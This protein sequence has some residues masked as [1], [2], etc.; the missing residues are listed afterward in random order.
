MT[1]TAILNSTM[2]PAL[3]LL[4]AVF[5]GHAEQLGRGWWH[6]RYVTYKVRN[7][8]A[9]YQGDI[10]L[11]N[12]ADIPTTPPDQA[13]Q[14][15]A[16]RPDGAFLTGIGN[17]NL[18]PGGIV[19]Y[20]IA[21]GIKGEQLA[22]V[23][24]AMQTYNNNTPVKWTPRTNQADYV[25]IVSEPADSGDCGS[26]YVGVNGGAQQLILN[27]AASCGYL[28]SATHE[29]GHALGF[30]HEQT[31]FDRDYY[32]KVHFENMDKNQV[33]QYARDLGQIDILPYN[34][35][36]IMHYGPEDDQRN[37]LLTMETIPPGIPIAHRSSL[38]AGD[39]E[40][41]RTVYGSPSS[42]VTVYTD[43]PG[44][45]VIVDGQSVTTPMVF[46]WTQGSS[47]TLAVA[48]G[49]QK[50]VNGTRYTFARWSNDGPKVQTITASPDTR[51]VG[52]NFSAQF[53][54]T[55]KVGQAG[56]GS[57]TVDP[58]SPDGYYT[59][60][61]LLT[62]TASP[63]AGNA[64]LQWD[65]PG[66]VSL[67][68]GD[69]SNP[70][71]L[72]VDAA[73]YSYVADFTKSPVTSIGT[74]IAGT[75]VQVD[76][77]DTYLPANFAWTP[78]SKHTLGVSAT[79]QDMGYVGSPFQW[80][81]QNWG[82]G[83]TT[84]HT[85]TAGNTS[86]TIT[87]NWQQKWL[88]STYTA[89][90]DNPYGSDNGRIS[91]SPASSEC[92]NPTPTDC[93][94]PVGTKLTFTPAALNSYVFTGW[95]DDLSGST[96]PGSITV[97]DQVYLTANF[98]QAGRLS[99]EGIVSAASYDN[100]GVS[101]GELIT[102]FGLDFGPPAQLTGAQLNGNTL[103]TTL[104]GTQVL[105]DGRAAPLI[106]V[107][108]NQISAIVPYEVAGQDSTRVV[109]SY[110]GKRGNGV[111]VP[112]QATHPALFTYDSSGGGL[113]AALNQDNSAHSVNNPAARG[114]VVQLFG[115]GMGVTT[116]ASVDGRLASQTQP[117]PSAPFK[118]MIAGR[119]AS[120][121]YFGA[122][123]GEVNGIFQANVL[124]PVDCPTGLVPISVTVGGYTSP[125]VTRIAVQ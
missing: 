76:G 74:N 17:A 28:A 110:Q 7:G 119:T 67:W 2:R 40:T 101:P 3:L 8:L 68:Q 41:V 48:D 120:V 97:N 86:T 69:S 124:I 32:V 24:Q 65:D 77:T 10:L 34:Q 66:A 83:G 103:A 61:T 36:S 21:A 113:V 53:L 81:F 115:T 98:A 12:A 43:P 56:G 51:V 27:V 6:G 35:A 117:T 92:N 93:Y 60:G 20:T 123:P 38:S 73:G 82:D 16:L 52:A 58:P 37:N 55:A 95:S 13:N 46:N 50:N 39:I 105:F 100:E 25:Q 99:S 19:P 9:V 31:R 29:M 116:P 45:A 47:H 42:T 89:D 107:S 22:A 4:V 59:Y 11:G 87:A 84:S 23:M 78:G 14:P 26:S 70:A 102:I 85:I 121:Q 72:V 88:V 104:A 118:V 49:F 15:R 114:T 94:Y 18:W 80:A 33:S 64:F 111:S 79:S 108:A 96:F 112:V 54:V 5:A 125:A 75:I 91:V 109:V 44:L 122:A 90:P 30:E 1:L 106:Y 57:I 63:A 62:I 71:T